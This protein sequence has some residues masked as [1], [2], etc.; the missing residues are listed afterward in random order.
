MPLKPLT[1][2][3]KKHFND[4]ARLGYELLYKSYEAE[5]DFVNAYRYHRR[6]DA[7]T[8]SLIN[9]DNLNY[10][11]R[12]RLQFENDRIK[13]E[14]ELLRKNIELEKSKKEK[15]VNHGGIWF[16]GFAFG[17]TFSHTN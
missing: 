13:R 10:I 15:T 2:P 9:L 16:A 14:N 11:A 6:F 4:R 8:D 1:W 17:Y 3:G 12:L 7:L 5:N